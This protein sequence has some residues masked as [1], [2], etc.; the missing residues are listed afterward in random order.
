MLGVVIICGILMLFVLRSMIWPGG[1]RGQLLGGGLEAQGIVLSA[2]RF[3]SASV[4]INGQRFETRQIVLDVEVPGKEPYEVS[5]TPAIPRICD[6]Y[7]GSRLDLRVDRR[8]PNNIAIV[9]PPGSIG[10]M[11]AMPNLFVGVPGAPGASG[12]PG[13]NSAQAGKMTVNVFMLLFLATVGGMAL[14]NLV[15]N[16]S[17]SGSKL[18]PAATRSKQ[19][20]LPKGETSS[21]NCDAAERCCETIGSTDCSAFV[22]LTDDACATALADERKTAHKMGRSCK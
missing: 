12:L 6:V 22:N 18:T 10:W 17:S 15:K 19:D 13:V 8:N 20:L 1:A 2:S 3:A 14:S 9:G 5:L 11:S 7:P 16:D 4:T 21:A